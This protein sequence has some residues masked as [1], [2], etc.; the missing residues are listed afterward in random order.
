MD[1]FFQDLRY[2]FRMMAKKPAFTFIVVIALAIGIG[3][4]TA[5]FSVVNAVILRP[6]PYKNPD[7]LVMVWMNNTR[8]GID[9]DWHSYPNYADYRDQNQTFETIAAFNNRSFTLTDEGEP[10]RVFG[11]WSTA[12]LFDVLGVQPAYGRAFTLEEEEPGKDAVV[13]LSDGL[14]KRRFGSDPQIVGQQINLSGRN[15]TVV[16]VM[17][18][19]FSFPE[20]DTEAWVPIALSPERKAARSFFSFKAIGLLKQNVSLDQARADMAAIAAHTAE[21]FPD[22]EGYG[23]N[24]VALHQQVIGSVRVAILAL[25]AAV[26]FVLLIACANVANLLLARAATRER[27]IAIRT[28]LGAGRGRLV[29]QLL[30][31]SLTLSLAG[32]ALGLL[33]AKFGLDA[34]I[35]LS[36]ADTPRLDS[37]GIDGRVLVFTLGVSLL[38]GFLFGLAPA[39]QTSRPDLNSTLKEGG[40][41]SGGSVRRNHVRST[42]VVV[43]VALSLLLLVGAGLMIKSFIRLQQFDLGFN[44]ERLVTMRVQ[45]SGAK[46]SEG[47][48]IADFYKQA[49][50]RITSLPG[51]ESAGAISDIFLSK[52]PNSTTFTIEGRPPVPDPERVEVPLDAVTPAYFQTMGIPLI[53]GRLFDDL[54]ADGKTP[55]VIINQT[56]VNRFFA[57]E[58][59]LGKRF[60]YGDPGPQNTWLTIVGVVGDMRRTGFDSEPRCETFLPHAQATS[61]GMTMI[62]RASADPANLI[63]AMRSRIWEIDKDQAIYDIRTIDA[64]LGQMM[65]QRRFNMMLFGILAAVALILASVGIYGVISYSVTQRTHEIGIRLALGAAPADVMKMI[66]RQG[67]L[68]ALAG[69]GLGLI[70]SFLLTRFMA[71]L[72]YT[73]SATDPATFALIAASL[74]GVALGACAVPARRALKVDPMVALRYE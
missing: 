3:A 54:D 11:S 26:G 17:P 18:A 39:L 27:E 44:P 56:F 9:Q 71:T 41:G 66:L 28:A 50:E 40:R 45:L 46:Y 63:G 37:V 67:I 62:V 7:R 38:T 32:G 30:T 73:V 61:T 52:T 57:D 42:L 31:E 16:G 15:R 35:A 19:G 49:V 1:N 12:N 13:V 53:R 6:L 64:M 69:V 43:E 21:Q 24:L 23:S 2:S 70:A 4:T 10:L 34:L 55:V 74:T 36:P 5:I 20:K 8:M 25:F 72:L 48:Q 47:N 33:V 60:C 58:D 65:S 29:R 14:W 22:Q 51:V 59:P 68:L